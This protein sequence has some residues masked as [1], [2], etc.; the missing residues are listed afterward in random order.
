MS[1]LFDI[2]ISLSPRLRWLRDHDLVLRETVTGAWECV[3]NQENIG[4]GATADEA[5][6]N[7]CLKTKLPHWTQDE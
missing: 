2:P 1:D 3:L 7:F 4:R 6:V 5:C